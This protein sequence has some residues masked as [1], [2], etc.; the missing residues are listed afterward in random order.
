MGAP[1]TSI[2]GGEIVVEPLRKSKRLGDP[3]PTE[4][5]TPTVAL[6]VTAEATPD[7][8]SVG[9]IVSKAATAPETCGA[10]IDVPL[11]VLVAVFEVLQAEVMDEP[12]AKMSTQVPKFEY[13]ARASVEVVAATVKALGARAG[14]V[15]QASRL[16]LPAATTTETPSLMTD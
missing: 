7:G 15:V 12:G 11:M 2:V 10:A 13:E 1:G 9:L 8:L 3:A 5:T 4:D 16:L 14:D 6:S